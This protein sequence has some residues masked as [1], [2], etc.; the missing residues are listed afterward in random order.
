M[1]HLNLEYGSSGTTR[2]VWWRQRLVRC[3]V[4]EEGPAGS[5]KKFITLH[6]APSLHYINV[7]K[8][9]LSQPKCLPSHPFQSQ[10]LKNYIKTTQNIEKKPLNPGSSNWRVKRCSRP[11]SVP[12]GAETKGHLTHD[13]QNQGWCVCSLP[14]RGWLSWVEFCP[15]M[16]RTEP[17]RTAGAGQLVTPPHKFQWH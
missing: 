1:V 9:Q 8:D 17:P 7:Q 16:L 13:F 6:L 4:E 10:K 5:V 2:K 15:D 3:Q 11:L 14:C 12:V